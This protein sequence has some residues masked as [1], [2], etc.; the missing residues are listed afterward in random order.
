MLFDLEQYVHV[1]QVLDDRFAAF[2]AVH[3]FIFAGVFVHRA[4]FVH[5]EDA[6]QVVAIADLE[7]VRVVCRR[8]LHG[9]ASEF[10]VDIIVCH[11]F[12]FTADDRQDDFF[13]DQMLVA[14]V[15]R[16]NRDCRIT[17]HRLGAGRRDFNMARSICQRI[18]HMVKRALYVFVDDFDIGDRRFRCRVPVDDVFAAVNQFLFV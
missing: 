12:N 4:V 11:D 1:L 2:E 8:D 10:T 5:D 18:A 15:F 6:L 16:V 14:F 13:A 9:A 3:A 7:V 17:E